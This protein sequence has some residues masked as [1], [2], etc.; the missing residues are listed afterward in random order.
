MAICS[1]QCDRAE[2]REAKFTFSQCPQA[3]SYVAVGLEEILV[4]L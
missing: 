1:A 3:N 4:V 2:Y